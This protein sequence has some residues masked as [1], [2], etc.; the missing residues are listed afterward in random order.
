ML[1]MKVPSGVRY[2][3]L[4]AGERAGIHASLLKLA[5]SEGL[6]DLLTGAGYSCLFRD[7]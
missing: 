4:W 5:S 6:R 1:T 7:R 2:R 3:S